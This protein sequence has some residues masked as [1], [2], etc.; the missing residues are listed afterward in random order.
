VR[1]LLGELKIPLATAIPSPR[2]TGQAA[3]LA[4]GVVGGQYNPAELVGS[5]PPEISVRQVARP[6]LA[7]VVD[8]MVGLVGANGC[9]GLLITEQPTPTVCLANRHRGVRAAAVTDAAG[10]L[11][12]VESVGANLLVVNPVSMP[13]SELTRL[14]ATFCGSAAKSCPEA[15]R[16]RLG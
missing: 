3:Q 6:G 16:E 12:A 15:F 10:A 7:A 14:T 8:E 11:E 1:D 9:L 5:L 13:L 2:A 4:V